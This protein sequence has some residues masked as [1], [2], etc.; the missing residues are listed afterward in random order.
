L[1]ADLG[2]DLSPRGSCLDLFVRFHGHV[3]IE[4]ARA[5]RPQALAGAQPRQLATCPPQARGAP[6][7][8]PSTAPPTVGRGTAQ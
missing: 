8:A 1:T 7:D 3:E 2:D 4:P 5:H 6:N